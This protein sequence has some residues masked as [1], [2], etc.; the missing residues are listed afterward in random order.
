M[1]TK[2]FP[3]FFHNRFLLR[4]VIIALGWWCLPIL[5][6]GCGQKDP[7]SAPQRHAPSG[8]EGTDTVAI[9]FYNVENLF[10][11]QLDGDEYPEYRPGAL[12]WNKQT[13][14]KKLR[15]IAGVIAAMRVDVVGLCEIESAEALRQLQRECG[16]NGV[17]YP[18]SA[19]ADAPYAT[20]TAPCLLSQLPISAVNRFGGGTVEGERRNIL[21]A[22]ILFSGHTLK[23]FVNHWPSKRHLESHRVAMAQALMQRIRS[24]PRNSE[25]VVLGDLNSDYDQWS[26][27]RTERLDD[28]RGRA[29]INH[30]LGTVHGAPGSFVSY[31][32][33][34][35]LCSD[36]DFRG[37]YNLWLELPEKERRSY[38]YRGAPLT[39]DHMLL[40]A[41]LFDTEGISYRDGSF[42]VFT[43]GGK[44]LRDSVPY[45]WQMRWYGK[46]RFH[47]GEGYSDHL[48]LR[49]MFITGPFACERVTVPDAA[50]QGTKTATGGFEKSF[51]GW[52][53]CGKGIS[54]VRDTQ[55]AFA[56]R[57]SLRLHGA[58]AAKNRCGGRTILERQSLNASRAN[59][60]RFAIRGS[61]N[62][63]IR[64]RSGTGKWRYY[65][66]SAFIPSYSARY[67]SVVIKRWK[68]AALPFT[69]DMPGSRECEVELRAGKNAPFDF[70]VD[71]VRAE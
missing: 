18:Y 23:L 34:H 70:W 65:N 3:G 26:R 28:T 61:G 5:L 10:D 11:L 21:E 62:L 25:Y 2:A 19:I 60:I 68:E 50:A 57:F 29:G 66:G 39:L 20:A 45:R 49:A 33:E 4:R 6:C 38:V 67:R 54:L 40:P 55:G 12:G 8:S 64:V 58:A 32:T 59:V 71:N 47:A 16:R 46:R 42:R 51:D 27:L 35:D 1:T 52:L 56:G 53:A 43:W 15:N 44:L 41:S 36:S 9:G 14:E 31:V 17:A 30:V 7:K 69:S 22:D 13:Q 63:S 37:H 24:L 48:P